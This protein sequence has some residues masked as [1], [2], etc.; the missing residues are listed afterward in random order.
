[1]EPGIDAIGITH[2]WD[3]TVVISPML[4]EKMFPVEAAFDIVV[5]E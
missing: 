5:K 3:T 1:M 2:A 4:N